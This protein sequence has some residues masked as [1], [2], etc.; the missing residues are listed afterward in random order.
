MPPVLVQAYIPWT[1]NGL[2]TQPAAPGEAHCAPMGPRERGALSP[3]ARLYCSL[4]RHDRELRPEMNG[5]REFSQ[6]PESLST[7]ETDGGFG[8]PKIF[9]EGQ[10]A[11]WLCVL[12]VRRINNRATYRSVVFGGRGS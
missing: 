1:C 7:G 4:L 6:T 3:V 2:F 9:S 11:L 12:T 10:V 8:L 5:S